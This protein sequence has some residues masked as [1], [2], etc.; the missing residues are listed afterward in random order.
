MCAALLLVVSV[1]PKPAHMPLENVQWFG[2]GDEP[3]L[4]VTA[5]LRVR[6]KLLT[7]LHPLR[8]GRQVQRLED[9]GQARDGGV[10]VLLTLLLGNSLLVLDVL[11]KKASLLVLVVRS[12]EDGFPLNNGPGRLPAGV[13][14]DL[15]VASQH[16][17]EVG[18]ELLDALLLA[19]DI[20]LDNLVLISFESGPAI[21][22][23][24]DGAVLRIL[25][26]GAHCSLP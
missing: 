5:E 10:I 17:A 1:I 12:A 14:L 23:L 4:F 19:L 20:F 7:C 18:A 24:F 25:D 6:L 2:W 22:G 26:G 8:L 15:R 16:G 13:V 21:V 3:V 9:Y 11:I